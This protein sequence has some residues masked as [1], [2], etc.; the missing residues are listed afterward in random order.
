MKQ[1]SSVG[2]DRVVLSWACRGAEGLRVVT[3]VHVDPRS[4][5]SDSSFAA[6]AARSAR[7]RS[8]LAFSRHILCTAGKSGLNWAMNSSMASWN[9]RRRFSYSRCSMA[10]IAAC[11]ATASAARAARAAASSRAAAAAASASAASAA[12][13]SAFSRATFAFFCRRRLSLLLNQGSSFSAIVVY[14]E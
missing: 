1:S 12:S 3:P 5:D 10:E 8:A 4:S 7:H 11:A 13:A 2:E 6:A 14:Y 9:A